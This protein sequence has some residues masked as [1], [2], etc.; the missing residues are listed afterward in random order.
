MPATCKMLQVE[1]EAIVL[2]KELGEAER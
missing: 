2:S 1:H